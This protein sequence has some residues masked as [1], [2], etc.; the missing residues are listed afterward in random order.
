MM[1]DQTGSLI[2]GQH[3]HIVGIG[4]FGMS[5][6]AKVLLD[7]G[8]TIS[9]SDQQH[10]ALTRQLQAEGATI[11]QGH[12][13]DHIAGAELVL[14]STAIAD[15]NP[16]LL[17]ARK[18]GIRIQERR[19]FITRMTAGYQ[20]IAIAGTHGKTTTSALL[21]H[22]LKEAGLDPSY[23]VGGMIRNY[24]SNAGSGS[25][26]QFVIEADEYGYMFLGLHPQIAVITNIEYDHPD[27]FKTP[28]DLLLAFRLFL[29][30]L[31][32]TGILVACADDDVVSALA[33]E[34]RGLV[35]PVQTYGIEN[36][37]PADWWAIDLKPNK[38]GGTD[39]VV[40]HGSSG[41]GVIG[42]ARLQIPG[43]HNV[44]NAMAVIAVARQ[45]GVP[46]E[47][48]AS[49]LESFEGAGR[50]SEVMG[51]AAGVRVVNDY[52]HHPTAISATL[53]AWKEQLGGQGRLWGVW[54]PHTY[55]R[56]RALAESFQEAFGAADKVLVMDI[57]PSREEYSP[58]LD[59]KDLAEKIPH[60]R[61]SGDLT[62]TAQMLAEEVK[63]GDTVVLMTA[64][65]AP[66]V[67]EMLLAVLKNRGQ[68]EKSS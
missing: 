60:A 29:E 35:A 13:A 33:D 48:I 47:V 55:S 61:H 21:T 14:M 45:L 10:N 15:D 42:P 64:G 22:V 50:R 7:Q 59:S 57:F 49:A 31:S 51:Q 37:N 39:F 24:A 52:A 65:D 46:F 26:D 18:Q 3:I 67:G 41:T 38:L 17:E 66:K 54:Q 6:I 2:P 53:K 34:R 16:E 5:A 12:Q 43:K 63:A 40:C 4:G 36:K 23:I 58:G 68:H 62:F 30:K 25:G 9:G 27:F 28:N 19:D 11:Y 32:L 20:T 44:Q 1:L 8:Y 56:T